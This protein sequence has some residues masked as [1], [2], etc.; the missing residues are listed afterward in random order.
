MIIK[1]LNFKFENISL[2]KLRKKYV[3]GSTA[4]PRVFLG[5]PGT[6]RTVRQTDQQKLW[7]YVAAFRCQA[8][9]ESYKI[10]R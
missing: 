7:L 6:E 1:T 9:K 10:I 3:G 4:V 8:T 2:T 5:I